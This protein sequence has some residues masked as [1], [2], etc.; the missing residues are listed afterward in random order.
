MI[1]YKAK[2]WLPAV[3]HFHTGPTAFALFRRLG[4]VLIYVAIVTTVEIHYFDTRLKDTPSSFL[5][6]MGILLS[7][8]LI[9][10]TN[11]AYDRFYEGR[12][13]WGALVNNSRNLAL[14]FNAVLPL[15]RHEDRLFFA[16]M[17]SNFPFALKN[18]LRGSTNTDEL[19]LLDD[20]DKQTLNR[21]DY[22]PGGVSSLLWN[23]SES[24][25]REGML[26]TSQHINL[27]QRL[28]AMMDVAGICDRIK[29]TPIPFSYNLF[30]KLFITIYV[31]VLP[32]TI[33]QAFGYMT[34]PAVVLTSY[35]LIGLELI[36]E[37]IEDPFGVDRNDLP[38]NQISQLIR[39]NVHDILNYELPQAEKQAAK[40]GFV[41]VT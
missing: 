19:E 41:I 2:S 14:Y 32:F 7:L 30:I 28:T 40:P 10:R 1:L 18:H 4:V 20:E 29:S 3:W 38:L 37:E 23:R 24:L 12:T 31:G 22:K 15:D 11:T 8:L 21:F 5:S 34:I 9:Y 25:Y 6:A 27:N 17:I 13:A 35:I 26:S 39:V 36:G 16:K 33:V